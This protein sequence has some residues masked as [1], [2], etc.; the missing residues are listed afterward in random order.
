MLFSSLRSLFSGQGIDLWSFF[1]QLLA[2]GVVLF[3]ALPIHELAHGWVANKLGDPTA[4]LEGRLTFNPLA[5]IDPV[6]ALAILLFGFG[7]AKPV[8]VNPR[9]FKNE[10]RDMAITAF[11]GPLS[12]FLTA[13]VAGFIYFAILSFLPY[14][15]F[16]GFLLTMFSTLIAI[17]ISL[18]VFNLLPVPPLD[19]SRIIGAFLSDKA[20]A[21]YYRY[22]SMLVNIL[23]IVILFDNFLGLGI[24]ANTLGRLQ[25]LLFN[26][27]VSLT[28]MPFKFFGVM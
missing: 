9:Y 27:V 28:S 2:V 26:A 20:L 6:G 8:P 21:S 16:V 25:S 7:W 15:K 4:K 11:A 5:S 1:A 17:S 23:F 19:G 3:I 24:Y 12:N 13:I 22:Q 10:K 18:C 14:N